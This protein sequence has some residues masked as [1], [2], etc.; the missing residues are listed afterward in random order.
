MNYISN[1]GNS[2]MINEIKEG[3]PMCLKEIKII[4]TF[5]EQHKGEGPIEM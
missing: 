1:D 3:Y 2:I 5:K 4:K